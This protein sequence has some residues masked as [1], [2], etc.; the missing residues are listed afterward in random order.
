LPGSPLPTGTV[1]FAVTLADLDGDHDLDIAVVN[2]SSNNLTVFINYAPGTFFLQ[3]TGSPFST[4]GN[5]PRAIAAGDF[6]GDGVV[7]LVV[8][9][10]NSTSLGLLIG[11]TPVYSLVAGAPRVEGTQP[12]AGGDLVF[13]VGRTSTSTAEDI[14]Y[15]LGGTAKAGIDYTTPG[16]V[17]F[18]IGQATALIHISI[19]PDALKEADESV[20]VALT[21][22]NAGGRI[23]PFRAIATGTIIDDEPK[24]LNGTNH[25]DRLNGSTFVDIIHGFGG[26]D[27]I[28][29]NGSGDRIAGGLGADRLT[30]N[31]G[32]DVFVFASILESA[33]HQSGL[34][35][36]RFTLS[37]GSAQ[38]DTIT[39][40][41]HGQDKIDLSA[42]DADTRHAGNQNFAWRGTGNFTHSPGQLIERLYNR[43][44][45]AA[46]RTVIYGDVNGDAMADFQIQ[47]VSLKHLVAGD[48]HL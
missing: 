37:A 4:G 39:D 40:F 18:A 22:G 35:D 17:H 20:V 43:P 44:G 46:D 42:I 12:G 28:R 9:N 45:T 13:T 14:S 10:T 32:Q 33:P 3:P 30:G 23:N 2:A 16:F 31:A 6:N 38:R 24:L 25:A 41:T 47:L 27:T 36:G 21:G 26:N 11:N 29:G 5:S 8:D 19:T 15:A 7:D 1:P 34:V 48:F